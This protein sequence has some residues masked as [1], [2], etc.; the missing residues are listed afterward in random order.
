MIKTY[1]LYT[2]LC[3]CRRMNIN[4][5]WREHRYVDLWSINHILSGV[6]LGSL[7]WTFGMPLTYSAVFAI[8]LFVGWEIGEVIYGINEHFSN[9]VM[10]VL[11]D[12]AGFAGAAYWYFVLGR[13]LSWTALSVWIAVFIVFNVWGFFAYEER[14][15]DQKLG[16]QI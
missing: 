12:I 10:D 15:I 5:L 1:V 16:S 7:L 6:V 14:K 13:P 9:I 8:V 2:A 4:H 11:F 3:Y